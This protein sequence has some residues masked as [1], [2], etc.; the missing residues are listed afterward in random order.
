MKY[1]I[2]ESQYKLLKEIEEQTQSIDFNGFS[3]PHLLPQF[4]IYLVQFKSTG[5][6][7]KNP[8]TEVFIFTD[9]NDGKEYIFDAD[10]VQKSGSSN[11]YMNLSDIRKKYNINFDEKFERHIGKLSEKETE[12]LFFE[13]SKDYRS[14][15]GYCN[16]NQCKDLRNVI[17]KSLKEIYPD[18]YGVYDSKYCEK[19]QGFLNIYP[20]PN[21]NN[22]NGF[23]WSKLNYII[24]ENDPI[25]LIV[26]SYIKQMKTFEHNDFIQWVYDNRDNLFKGEFLKTLL[27]NISYKPTFMS[28]SNYEPHIKK[29]LP[30]SKVVQNFCPSTKTNYSEIVVVED[31][32]K[33]IIF[34]PVNAK[35]EGIYK[36]DDKYY[37]PFSK[38]VKP[39]K[40][41]Y[42][43]DFIL[44]SNGPIYRNYKIIQGRSSWESPEPP[45]YSPKNKILT[46]SKKVR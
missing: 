9:V 35:N 8:E 25:S 38:T 18:N 2:T 1:I 30:N 6:F 16:T 11:F 19:T 28:K 21:S 36:L 22:E 46:M 10:L 45:V 24:F 7:E 23:S 34:Q 39:P 14:N 12:R 44:I 27:T 20:L 5:R 37:I 31:D 33:E 42:K 4:G 29:F 3:E 17:E 15:T 43:S 26:K 13:K 32:G 40:L 41:S